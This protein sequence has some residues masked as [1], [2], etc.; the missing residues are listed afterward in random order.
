MHMECR[1]MDPLHSVPWP[2]RSIVTVICTPPKAYVTYYCGIDAVNAE[3]GISQGSLFL[4]TCGTH[5]HGQDLV[6]EQYLYLP[7]LKNA[8]IAYVT[9]ALGAIGAGR[10]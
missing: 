2:A 4:A 8:G 3:Q 7:V 6:V 1:K 9:V 10:I 5:S